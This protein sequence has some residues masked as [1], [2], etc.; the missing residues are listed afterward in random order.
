MCRNNFR[1]IITKKYNIFLSSNIS[2]I[3][4]PCIKHA[5]T[6]SLRTWV[7][8][9]HV[10]E[11][12]TPAAHLV[13][14]WQRRPQ[15]RPGNDRSGWTW[16]KHRGILMRSWIHWTALWNAVIFPSK[17][18][19]PPKNMS[20]NLTSAILNMQEESVSDWLKQCRP[21]SFICVS[22]TDVTCFYKKS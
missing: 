15:L 4:I 19:C 12:Q 3:F 8:S 9:S 10:T 14:P 18:P 7:L 6:R 5:F 11:G 20:S 13:L 22:V 21:H 16:E 2:S 1:Q 17:K